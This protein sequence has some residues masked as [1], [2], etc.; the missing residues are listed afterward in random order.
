MT[1][2]F[3]CSTC[4]VNWPLNYND[5][6]PVCSERVWGRDEAPIPQ[7]EALRLRDQAAQDRATDHQQ[8][9]AAHSKFEEFWLRREIN[10]LRQDLEDWNANCAKVDT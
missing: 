4:G 2:S 8:Q 6:C 7:R 5:K 9:D 1:R 3:C 10:A